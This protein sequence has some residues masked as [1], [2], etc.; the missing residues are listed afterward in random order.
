M[1]DL[2]AL[3]AALASPERRRR[4]QEQERRQ[5]EGLERFAEAVAAGAGIAARKINEFAEAMA[6]VTRA[7]RRSLPGL[8]AEIRRNGYPRPEVITVPTPTGT[9]CRRIVKRVGGWNA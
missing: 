4:L 8:R 5:V 6:E 1:S 9:E 7:Q 3:A 2:S